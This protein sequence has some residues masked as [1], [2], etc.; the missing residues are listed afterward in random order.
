MQRISLKDAVYESKIIAE[1][2]DW[3]HR[4]TEGEGYSVRVSTLAYTNFKISASSTEQAIDHKLSY[5]RT[6]SGIILSEFVLNWHVFARVV[7]RVT[8]AS[9]DLVGF[10]DCLSENISPKSFDFARGF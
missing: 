10:L 8:I 2:H 5:V 4:A 3:H 9:M 1:R 6:W 7:K